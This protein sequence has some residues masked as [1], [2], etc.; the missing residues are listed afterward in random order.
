MP[1]RNLSMTSSPDRSES[2]RWGVRSGLLFLA[3]IHFVP[4]LLAGALISPAPT[5]AEIVELSRTGDAVEGRRLWW[6]HCS[7]CHLNRPESAPALAVTLAGVR[8]GGEEG[9]RIYVVTS[10][11]E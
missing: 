1:A 8:R 10:I 5:I 7:S 2:A 4:L 9:L 3:T 6:E 11:L